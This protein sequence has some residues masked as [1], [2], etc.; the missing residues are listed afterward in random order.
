MKYL[1]LI[2]LALFCFSA[3]GFA[4]TIDYSL[5]PYR[6]GDEWGFA[7]VNRKVIIKPAYDN[8]AWFS[9]GYAAVEKNG[10]WG[11]INKAGKLVIPIKF[12]VAK[13]FRKGFLPNHT[14]G[15]DSV[16]F[17]GASVQADGYE[18]CINT[19]GARMPKCPAIPESAIKENNIPIKTVQKQKTYSLPNS[20]GLFDKIVD[21]Y[22][23]P[24][25]DEKYYIAIKDS[26]YGVFN[27][28]FTTIIPFQYDLIEEV[29]SGNLSFL[30]L[31]KNG[32]VG[33]SNGIGTILI[34]PDYDKL[35]TIDASDGKGYVIVQQ[36]GK[37]FVKDLQNNNV[38]AT[39][40]ADI[41]YDGQKGFIVTNSSN[42]KGYYFM[43]G[44][45]ITPKY[46]DILVSNNG[47]YILVKTFNGKVGYL[48]SAG[49]EF[50]VE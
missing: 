2:C 10:K 47:N 7:D 24:N 39:G 23:L 34:E 17:A 28:K 44:K 45:K 15:G 30:Q 14:P 36:H 27:S 40:F 25:N 37:Y 20:E 3:E 22:T 16:L 19:K 48:N 8:V 43:D 32:K 29:K 4:Q 50:F 11:Y 41:E 13:S 1:K 12:T 5:V 33:L 35:L 46:V 21:D 26:S 38:I 31:T 9:E 49:D 18:I 42:L 6:S